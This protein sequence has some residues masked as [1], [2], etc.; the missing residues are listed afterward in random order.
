VSEG[1]ATLWP[2]VINHDM[3]AERAIFDKSDHDAEAAADARTEADIAA[4]RLIGHDKVAAWLAK[5]RTPDVTP[6]PPE[7]LA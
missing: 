3:K 7:W 6:A 5:W 4:D 1:L 2:N